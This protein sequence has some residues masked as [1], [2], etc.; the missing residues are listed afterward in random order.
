MPAILGQARERLLLSPYILQTLPQVERELN[1]WRTRAASIP[2]SELRKQALASIAGKRFHCQGG[3]VYTLY[4][5]KGQARP[6]LAFIVALQT[7]SDYLDNLSDR[8]PGAEEASLRGL[9]NAVTEAVDPAAERSC[10][11]A[12]YPHQNDGGYLDA[13]VSVCRQAITFFPGYR[14]VQEEVSRLA[15]LYSDLQVLK[16]L[17]AQSHPARLARWASRPVSLAPGVAWWESAA[18]AGST[19]GILALAAAAAAG[20][21]CRKTTEGLL[22]CYF[23]WLAGLHILL[24][25]FID[26]DEDQES[27]DVN[28]VACY[29]DLEAAEQG[30]I[31]FLDESL[32]RVLRLPRPAFHL[33]VVKGLLALYL[34]DPKAL[35]PTRKKTAQRLLRAGGAET[36]WLHR[37]C[38]GLRR[39][40]LI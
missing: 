18:A 7:I 1:V 34:S 22:A 25:Y 24:D 19:L 11:Y 17:E 4:V 39:V 28:F 40:G 30:L 13:L 21:V 27:G 3:A 37:F 32:H 10:W 9:H 16:H 15:S 33:M 36:L 26:L 8:V 31:R 23:P 38:L 5:P 6:L 20:P 2:D 29:P 35:A 14:D 12:Y